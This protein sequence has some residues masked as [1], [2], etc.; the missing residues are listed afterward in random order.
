MHLNINKSTQKSRPKFY[1]NPC[2]L[3]A[4]TVGPTLIDCVRTCA[5]SWTNLIMR[6]TPTRILSE[7]V[8]YAGEAPSHEAF[9]SSQPL[10][11]PCRW[12]YEHVIATSSYAHW[13]VERFFR[14]TMA[15][16]R[17]NSRPSSRAI[18]SWMVDH[19]TWPQAILAE[20]MVRPHAYVPEYTS[21]SIHG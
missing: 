13:L 14:A 4:H 10:T 5:C 8:S 6:S 2:T 16:A 9:L 20:L 1:L 21:I 3:R 11:T 18:L 19:C 15:L 12:H 17:A 7:R